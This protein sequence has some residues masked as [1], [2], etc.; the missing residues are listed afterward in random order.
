MKKTTQMIA[1]ILLA[2]T[3]A[4]GCTTAALT[5]ITN[6]A[7]QV[8][9]AVFV[10]VD[11]ALGPPVCTTA[12]EIAQAIEALVTGGSSDDAGA[13]GHVSPGSAFAVAATLTPAQHAAVYQWL[14]VH[15]THGTAVHSH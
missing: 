12:L 10:A 4:V 5:Q 14:T 7:G 6:A 13:V 9:E 15:G 1:G 2:T 3:V 11:P 8:C